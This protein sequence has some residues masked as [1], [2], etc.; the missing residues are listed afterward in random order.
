M[1]TKKI[2]NEILKKAKK[3][4]TKGFSID[5]ENETIKNKNF[6]KVLYTGNNTQL[7]LMSLKPGEDIGDEAHGVDQFFRFEK[8]TGKVTINGNKY[9]VSDGF[10][11]IVPSGSKHNVKNDGKEDLKLYSLYSPPHHAEGTVHETKAEALKDDEHFDGE[12]TE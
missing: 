3:N 8:G 6:R 7:V 10:S 12:T 11:I 2:A 1:K 9:E 4:T 5:I